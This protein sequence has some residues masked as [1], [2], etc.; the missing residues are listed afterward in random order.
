MDNTSKNAVIKEKITERKRIERNL[1]KKA[2]NALTCLY[3]DL[4]DVRILNRF[5]SEKMLFENGDYIMMWDLVAELRLRAKEMDCLTK[6]SGTDTATLT[7][8]LLS[9]TETNP[10]ELHYLCPV[11]KK[12]EFIKDKALPWD[13]PDK[14][15]ECGGVMSADGF[16]IPYE[17]CISRK[18]G[19]WPHLAVSSA[20]MKT[21]E[22]IVREKMGGLYRICKLTKPEFAILKFVFLPFDGEQDYEEDVDTV[23][24]KYNRLPQ[25]TIMSTV[26]QDNAKKLSEVTGIDF[27]EV[28]AEI[29]ERYLSDSRIIT[30]FKNGDIE[31]I[32]GFYGWRHPRV[33]ELC[34]ELKATAPK[35]SYDLLKY[36]GTMQGTSN[37]W[38]NAESLVKD[39]ICKIGDIPSHRDDIFMIL[40]ERLKK[41]GHTDVGI[42][43]NIATKIRLGV[44]SRVGISAE[45]RALLEYLDLPEWFIPYVEK[46]EY[47]TSKSNSISSLRIAL[48]FMWYKVNH[49]ETFKKIVKKEGAQLG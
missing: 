11:C 39:G 8:F 16:D 30:A 26:I 37:W 43:H 42:A 1:W 36:L 13:L 18:F 45:D 19:P 24:D 28:T 7:A 6:L 20:F 38:D 14:P 22:E 23:D 5:Y 4:P 44:Y 31:W 21:A 12:V 41:A 34:E 17:M 15:C 32:P 40:R 3:G 10:L 2:H 25:I 29:S 48:A 46:I 33:S 27:D 47:M 35:N 49:P 9:A